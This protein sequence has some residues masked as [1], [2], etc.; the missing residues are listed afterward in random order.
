MRAPKFWDTDGVIPQMLEPLSWG[1][2][3]IGRLRSS[4]AEPYQPPI[5]VIC[6]GNLVAGGAGKTPTVLAIGRFL[7]QQGVATHILS[8]GYG[9]R[10]K[11]PTRV[12]LDL[13]TAT[14]VGDEPLLH[15]AVAPSWIARNR[16]R[17]AHAAVAAGA[18]AI[19]MDDGFQNPGLVKDLSLLVIDSAYGFGNGRVHPAGPLRE[20]PV[21]GLARADGVVVLQNS[22]PTV[23]LPDLDIPTFHARLIPDDRALALRGRRVLAFAGIGRPGRFFH[24]LQEIGA[25]IEA[26]HVFSDHHNFREDEVWWL[27]EEAQKLDALAV[28]TAKDAVRLPPAARGMVTIVN[29]TLLIDDTVGFDEMLN[30]ILTAGKL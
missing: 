19:V 11:G 9:G 22:E 25:D 28:T 7:A 4:M 16:V 18:Q 15:A 20:T 6:V 3:A 30:G 24:T 17:G 8:R 2:A 23:F 13:H 10:L 12:D 27:L 26:Q 29:V 21:D 14:D 1:Y 5:P